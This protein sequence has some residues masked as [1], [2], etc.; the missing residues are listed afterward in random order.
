VEL[1]PD[2]FEAIVA[3]L[4]DALIADLEALPL[5]MDSTPRGTTHEDEAA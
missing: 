4:S 3:A 1:P 2:L 5:R